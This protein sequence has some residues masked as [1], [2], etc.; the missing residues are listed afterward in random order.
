M[1]EA[2]SGEKD[3]M[4]AIGNITDAE[5][6]IV[7]EDVTE[8]EDL[9]EGQ[10]WTQT[11]EQPVYQSIDQSKLVPLLTAALQEALDKIEALESR[12]ETLENQ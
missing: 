4:E 7:N 12:I 5:G 1:P 8:P 9:G 11:G 10:T 6:T 3:G 2:I